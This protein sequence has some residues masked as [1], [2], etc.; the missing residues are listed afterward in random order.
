[1]LRQCMLTP[2]SK[3]RS[4]GVGRLGGARRGV[5]GKS[6]MKER[7]GD[8]GER[9]PGEALAACTLNIRGDNRMEGMA[10]RERVAERSAGIVDDV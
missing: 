10:D 9:K 5:K 7:G 4:F 2:P 1:M 3:R 8:R 6:K